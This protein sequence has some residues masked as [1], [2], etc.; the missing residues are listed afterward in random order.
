LT[1]ANRTPTFDDQ[2]YKV[3]NNFE[4][5]QP[6]PQELR[7]RDIR[8]IF[9]SLQDPAATAGGTPGITIGL[10][11]EQ[12]I[13]SL[14][15]G[16][17][18]TLVFQLLRD[19]PSVVVALGYLGQRS[20]LAI[21]LQ[22]SDTGSAL[23]ISSTQISQEADLGSPLTYS[24]R[25]ERSTVDVRSFSLLAGAAARHQPN[26]AEPG[27][28]APVGSTSRPGDAGAAPALP[29][30]P[31]GRAAGH[32]PADRLL[33]GG[34]RRGTPACRPAAPSRPR[35]WALPAPRLTTPRRRADRRPALP[36]SGRRQMKTCGSATPAPAVSQRRAAEAP[37]GWKV[38]FTPE[39]IA[40]LSTCARGVGPAA[41]ELPNG[42]VVGD[43][44][45]A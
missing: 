26:F 41:I 2:Q 40:R 22:Q 30:G 29:R 18:R 9:V 38:V 16:E 6:I 12:Q 15:Y 25:L 39:K 8:D 21:Q 45:R 23:N 28:K 42:A 10:P 27:T 1:V 11:Y 43:E 7:T 3:L 44:I 34:G 37:A 4:G 33:R 5:A 36:S 14:K 32:R 17:R 31:G 19:V 24:L 20:E 35:R 13:P